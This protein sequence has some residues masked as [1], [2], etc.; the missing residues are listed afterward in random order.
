MLQPNWNFGNRPPWNLAEPR[1]SATLAAS[2]PRSNQIRRLNLPPTQVQ[3]PPSPESLRAEPANLPRFAQILQKT[4]PVALRDLAQLRQC[5]TPQQNSRSA[6]HW[7]ALGESCR[8]QS[9][10]QIARAG[11]ALRFSRD[12]H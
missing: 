6:A 7:S 11:S 12:A 4:L 2:E 8:A 10:A 9:R 1:I 3:S 5:P